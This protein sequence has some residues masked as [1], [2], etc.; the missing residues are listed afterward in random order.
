MSLLVSETFNERQK[1]SRDAEWEAVEEFIRERAPGR[2]LD[3]GCGTGYAMAQAR[4]LGFNVTGIDPEAGRYGVQDKSVSDISRFIINGVAEKLPFKNDSFDV[5]YSSNAIEHFNDP[6]AGI[7]EIARVLRPM[8]RSVLLVPTG[9]MALL[10]LIAMY[11]FY[12]HRSIGKFLLRERSLTNL[13]YIFL[14][15]PHGSEAK[16]AHQEINLFSVK[17]W[18]NLISKHLIIERILMPCLYPWP[19]YPQFLPLMRLKHFSSSVAFICAARKSSIND[20][21]P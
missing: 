18:R 1:R 7:A 9:M 6:D 21:Q 12:T 13:K 16:Y 2:F 3:V 4:R 15:P 5:V 20:A 11:P 17:R 14:P 10:R 19:D 8:G